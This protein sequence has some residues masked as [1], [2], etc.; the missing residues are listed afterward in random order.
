MKDT[1]TILNEII[2]AAK[3]CGQVMLQ[4]DR[5]NFG[6]KDKA[7]KANFVTAYDCKIQEMLQIKLAQILPDAEFLGEEEDCM[8]NREAEYIFVVDP[9]DGTTNF[10]KDYHMSCVSIGLIRNG[11]RYLGVVHNP[12]LDET[13]SAISGEGAYMNG[14]AIHVSSDDLENGVVLFGSSPYNTEL[15]KASFKLAYEYFQKCLDIRRSGSAALDLCSI[16]SGR[17]ELYFELILSPW[18]FA[19]GALIVEEAGGI[20]TT[21]EGG[22]LPCLEKSSVLARNK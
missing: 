5:N 7:G 11:K 9:I 14:N 15:A 17:A 19:A 2:V 3:E 8:I 6:I 21:V 16:A 4:A 1:H 13:F 12:Y 20:V 22:A 10:I 18:D